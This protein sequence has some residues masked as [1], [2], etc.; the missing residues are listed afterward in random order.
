MSVLEEISAYNRNDYQRDNFD[1]FLKKVSFKYEIPS[2]HVTGTNGKGSTCNYINNIY[3]S[4][5]KKVGLFISPF[6]ISMLDMIRVNNEYISKD[7]AELLSK[8]VKN[9]RYID[10]STVSVNSLIKIDEIDK[11]IK[12]YKEDGII[13]FNDLD[14]IN[15]HDD[16]FKKK[17]VAA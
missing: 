7:V 8:A 3:I 12:L 10:N 5:G 15:M 2:I 4:S 9:Y 14:G 17:F 16:N 6:F 13:V 11:L 1:S